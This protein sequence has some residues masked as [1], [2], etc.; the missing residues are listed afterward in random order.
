MLTACHVSLGV[1]YVSG[2]VE[3]ACGLGLADAVIDLVETGTTMRAAGLE[4]VCEVMSTQ[5]VLISNPQAKHPKLVSLLNKRIQG[6]LAA[7]KYTMMNYNIPRA[8]I[9][10]AFAITPGKRSPTVSPLEDPE[11]VSV[12]ALV[13][14]KKVSEIMDQL[15]DLGATDILVFAVQNCRV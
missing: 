13:E 14:K 10:D 6:C 1:K 11:W 9:S 12:G 5:A 4:V 15:E 2:S 7:Q 8:K 3:A